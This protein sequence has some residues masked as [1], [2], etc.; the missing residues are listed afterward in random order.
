MNETQRQITHYSSIVPGE[1]FIVSGGID[2]QVITHYSSIVP[3]E[4]FIVSG[5]IDCQVPA[6]R[7]QIPSINHFI[8]HS[9]PL[10]FDHYN[11]NDHT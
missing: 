7:K 3:G 8:V 6:G 1:G 4:G 10:L 5:G 2:C 11:Y 9:F